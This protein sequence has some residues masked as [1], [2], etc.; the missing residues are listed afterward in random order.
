M[1]SDTTDGG[2]MAG[3]ASVAAMEKDDTYEGFLSYLRNPSVAATEEGAPATRV[4]RSWF[5]TDDP[6]IM[7]VVEPPDADVP[8]EDASQAGAS[9]DAENCYDYDDDADVKHTP[10]FGSMRRQATYRSLLQ[11]GHLPTYPGDSYSFLSIHG[12]LEEPR[13]FL[14]GLGVWFLQM[15][16]LTLMI[17]SLVVK[18]FR[19]D[20]NDNPADSIWGDFLPSDVGMVTRLTQITALL[21]YCIFSDSS[22]SDCIQAVELF[23]DL[24]RAGDDDGV[25]QAVFSCTL[26]FIQGLLA[27]AA[28]LLLIITTADV[29]EIILN[30]AA[31]NYISNLDEVSR[32]INTERL[33]WE[34]FN[35]A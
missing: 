24:K 31:V 25:P 17:V 16:F 21:C 14:F 10:P 34:M 33:N 19:V 27:T 8:P 9:A 3:D 6:P 2:R 5:A 26:R 23:P 22:L 18:R 35:N 12:P 11:S 4:R 28:T 30:F 20:Q 15:M 7:P 32:K 13:F 1:Q 29:V